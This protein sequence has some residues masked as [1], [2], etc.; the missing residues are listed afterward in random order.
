MIHMHLQITA[1]R[2]RCLADHELLIIVR[3]DLQITGHKCT[4][5][6]LNPLHHPHDTLLPSLDALPSSWYIAPIGGALLTD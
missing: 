1:C 5:L 6:P 2:P 4:T 3:Q